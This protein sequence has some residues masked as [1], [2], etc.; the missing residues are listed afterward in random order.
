MHR[1]RPGHR[2]QLP[3]SRP[4]AG[5]ATP[6]RSAPHALRDG[7][8]LR[9]VA[10]GGLFGLERAGRDEGLAQA[11]RVRRGGLALYD[12][13][14]GRSD[15][16]PADARAGGQ[17]AASGRSAP[18]SAS[19]TRT[20]WRCTAPSPRRH[21]VR[22]RQVHE[23]WDRVGADGLIP[24]SRG[25]MSADT[26]SP[27]WPTT[28]RLLDPEL[29]GE[30]GQGGLRQI[31]YDDWLKRHR[32]LGRAAR[33][34]GRAPH[35]GRAGHRHSPPRP[36]SRRRIP[37]AICART[38]SAS[39]TTGCFAPGGTFGTSEDDVRGIFSPTSSAITKGWKSKRLLLYAHGGLT[40]RGLGDSAARGPTG[41][42]CWR[43]RS[44]RS[45]SS[46]RP[47]SGPR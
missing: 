18:T 39:A 10:R 13:S 19:T 11:R 7:Q 38:S 28:A 46:G 4:E 36:P 41:R 32:R 6:D 1:L 14:Q 40:E 2:R 30:M 21:P 8:A 44:I 45:R 42:R 22:H 9:R 15:L 25:K 37:T 47:I 34:A 20:S 23:G 17:G 27:S 12:Q 24:F 33:R 35:R 26:P 16:S 29:V 43:P 5:P 31:S 3:A